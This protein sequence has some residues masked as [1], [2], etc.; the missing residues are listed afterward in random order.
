M[1]GFMTDNRPNFETRR[2][3]LIVLFFALVPLMLQAA[4]ITAKLRYAKRMSEAF[5]LEAAISPD[6][7]TLVTLNGDQ[8]V[9]IWD[10]QSGKLIKSLTG[11]KGRLM[12]AAISDDG[13]Y[14]ATG[15]FAGEKIKIWELATGTFLREFAQFDD[16]ASLA[17]SKNGQM[18]AISGI[19]A[20]DKKNC[21]VELWDVEKGTMIATL[22]KKDTNQFYPGS[23]RFSPDGKFLAA[24]IQNKMHSIMLWD[25]ASKKLAKTI[26]HSD[27]VI[28][29]DFS[30]DGSRI[31]GG[32]MGNKTYVW[33]TQTGTALHTIPGLAEHTTGV[34]FH[35]EGRYFAT[36]SFG[37]KSRFRV[38]DS[39]IGKQAYV[40]D[41]RGNTNNIIFSKDGR[42]L[43]V[44]IMTYGNLGDPATLEAYDFSL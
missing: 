23:L 6:S 34:S 35:P 20:G 7:K 15:S 13:R 43:V 21:S 24:G 8:T 22:M 17:F 12:K 11:H 41:G 2:I 40:M 33:D 25:V 37:G 31:V 36:S 4:E 3:C 1:G 18:L 44:I 32:G 29:I 38:W 9:G 10:L 16:L 26:K 30:P 19:P 28:A 42:T 14:L 39:Q 5:V 27:D